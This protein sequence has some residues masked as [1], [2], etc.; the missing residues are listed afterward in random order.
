MRATAAICKSA[1]IGDSSAVLAWTAPLFN[2][3]GSQE[4]LPMTYNI[5]SGA[6]SGSETKVRSGLTVLT[7]TLTGFPI[8]TS[9]YAFVT[10][11]DANG[12]GPPSAEQCKSYPASTSPPAARAGFTMS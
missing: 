11:Q 7:L 6:T 2:T 12:E 1:A 5:Y 3:D 4:T 10:A 9:E 8:G